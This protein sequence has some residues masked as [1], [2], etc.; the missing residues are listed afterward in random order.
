M[1]DTK[2]SNR[3]DEQFGVIIKAL[4]NHCHSCK[5]CP[6]ADKKPESILGKIMRW[7]RSWCPAQ[8]A[9][10]KVYGDKPIS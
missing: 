9:H 8:A 10:I 7:H 1:S 6:I 4:A 5:I 2:N 3:K